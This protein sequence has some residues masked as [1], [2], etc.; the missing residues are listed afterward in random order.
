[1][2]TE[3]AVVPFSAYPDDALV[4]LTTVM[5]LSGQSKSAV[6]AAAKD[7]TMPAPEK[8]GRSRSSGWRVGELRRWLA[9]P[10][11]YVA[12]PRARK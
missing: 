5:W 3:S 1:M 12:P 11:G 2:L 8:I 10:S 4:R 9:D 6:Y 7:G